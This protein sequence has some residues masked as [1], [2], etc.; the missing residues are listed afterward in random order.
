MEKG[1]E[2]AKHFEDPAHIPN[3]LTEEEILSLDMQTLT[4]LQEAAFAAYKGDAEIT[5]EVE[6][7]KKEP[8]PPQSA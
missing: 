3:P 8:A 7:S 2:S 6:E 4:A 1:Y 5:V